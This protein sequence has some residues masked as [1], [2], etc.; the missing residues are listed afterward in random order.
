[1]DADGTDTG[2]TGAAPA[3][4]IE[5]RLGRLEDLLAITGLLAAYGPLVDSGSADD[6]AALWTEDGVYDVEGLRMGSRDDVRTMVLSRPHQRFIESGSLHFMGSPSITLH[7]D[8]ATAICESLLVLHKDGGFEIARG[9][10]H[11]IRLVRTT[12]GWRIAER[13]ARALDGSEEARGLL[14]P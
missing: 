13:T 7:G 9:G 6:V 2:A 4:D 3:A 11:R 10:A 8:S 12:E 14:R 1:M 5:R